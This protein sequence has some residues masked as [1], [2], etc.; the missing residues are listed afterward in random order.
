MQLYVLF[1]A[2]HNVVNLRQAFTGKLALIL[3]FHTAHGAVFNIPQHFH[4]IGKAGLSFLHRV[5]FRL[6]PYAAPAVKITVEVKT[7]TQ[8]TF[9]F[10]LGMLS[11]FLLGSLLFA[12]LFAFCLLFAYLWPVF[13]FY[14]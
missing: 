11:G 14:F 8:N 1:D 12:Y 5:F 7:I 3:C 10:I 4:I 2:V 13:V 6:R 9:R